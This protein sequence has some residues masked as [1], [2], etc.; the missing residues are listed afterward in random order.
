MP[1]CDF[2]VWILVTKLAPTYYQ[3]LDLLL[4]EHPRYHELSSWRKGF[5]KVWRKLEKTLINMPINNA[6]RPKVEKWNCTCPAFAVSRFLICKHL[7]QH[8]HHVPP[9]YSSWK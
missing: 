4:N 1:R 8:V 2:L 9:P 5:K 6:Y 3:K 7:I